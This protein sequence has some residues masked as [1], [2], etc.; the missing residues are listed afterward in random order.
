MG[1]AADKKQGELPECLGSVPTNMSRSARVRPP[2][3]RF[4]LQYRSVRKDADRQLTLLRGRPAARRF[5]L[6]GD[7]DTGTVD[8]G[9]AVLCTLKSVDFKKRVEVSFSTFKAGWE[10]T[11]EWAL[12]RARLSIPPRHRGRIEDLPHHDRCGWSTSL[13]GSE[14]QLSLAGTRSERTRGDAAAFTCTVRM[15]PLPFSKDAARAHAAMCPAPGARV[16]PR[17]ATWGRSSPQCRARVVLNLKFCR[18]DA[19]PRLGERPSAYRSLRTGAA[20]LWHGRCR[21]R[22]ALALRSSAVDRQLAARLRLRSGPLGLGALDRGNPSTSA[23][24]AG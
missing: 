13:D 23:T 5:G 12:L 18:G 17:C 11:V 22:L 19:G 9:M 7:E 3:R 8:M 16:R 24:L 4:L 15:R 21:D 14:V 2:V 6:Q 10:G 1:S 20:S